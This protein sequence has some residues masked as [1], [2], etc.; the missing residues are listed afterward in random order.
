MN[1]MIFTL[2]SQSTAVVQPDQCVP[3]GRIDHSAEVVIKPLG[4][5]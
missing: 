4:A 2:L 1:C 3:V 5:S